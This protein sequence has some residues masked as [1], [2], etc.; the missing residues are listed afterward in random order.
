MSITTMEQLEALPDGQSITIRTSA[1]GEQVWQ[2]ADGLFLREGAA[3]RPINFVGAVNAGQVTTGGVTDRIGQAYGDIRSGWLVYSQEGETL[4]TLRFTP[5]AQPVVESHPRSFFG[6]RDSNWTRPDWAGPMAQ[7]ARQ[8]HEA[9]NAPARAGI[10]VDGLHRFIAERDW[11][12]T[13]DRDALDG[14]LADQGHAREVEHDVSVRMWG[15]VP[16]TVSHSDARETLG[17]AT[18]FDIVDV[19]TVE[20][21][22][23]RTVTFAKIGT[24]GGCTCG[25]VSST[26]LDPWLPSGASL[27]DYE[28]ECA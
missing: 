24:G 15:T 8:L 20:V 3:V 17:M 19:S 2:K 13:D 4:H 6:T 12:D 28:V 9:R 5:G 22:W 16:M 26:D 14:W 7:V 11:Y 21:E 27:A 18:D 25:E 10:E 1:L 23:E